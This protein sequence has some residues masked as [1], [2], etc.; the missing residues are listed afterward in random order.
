VK[1]VRNRR[2]MLRDVVIFSVGNGVLFG[3][4]RILPTSTPEYL[5]LLG[6]SGILAFVGTINYREGA[7]REARR[8]REVLDMARRSRGAA[9]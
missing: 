6:F 3:Y 2:E 5:R 8:L 7:R 4:Y 9:A 1:K